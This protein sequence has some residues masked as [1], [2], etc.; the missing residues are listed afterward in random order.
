MHAEF[1]WILTLASFASASMT[2]A[3]DQTQLI[4]VGAPNNTNH[5][6]PSSIQSLHHIFE[7]NSHGVAL[8]DSHV[9]SAN[10]SPSVLHPSH[11]IEAVH[12]ISQKAQIVTNK[13]VTAPISVRRSES[14]SPSFKLIQRTRLDNDILENSTRQN[15][16]SNGLGLDVDADKVMDLGEGL[17]PVA[18]DPSPLKT[19]SQNRE[20]RTR[21]LTQDIVTVAFLLFVFGV[22]MLVTCM[23]VYQV[24]EDSSPVKFY[25]DAR[26]RRNRLICGSSDPQEFLRTFC[27]PPRKIRLRLVGRTAPP[28]A[29]SRRN[30]LSEFVVEGFQRPQRRGNFL[31]RSSIVL[32][33]VALDVSAFVTTDGRLLGERDADALR[34]YLQDDESNPLLLLQLRKSVEWCGWEDVGTNIRQRLRSLGYTG[35]VDVRFE[36]TEEVLIYQNHPWQN[37]THSPVTQALV[38][39]SIVGFL[40]WVPYIWLRRRM[41]T[42]DVTFK[43]NIALDQYW[44]L[45]SEGLDPIDGFQTGRTAR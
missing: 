8:D 34:K 5:Q 18:Y 28:L 29:E 38:L 40:V 32:F 24:S 23:S 33:D 14:I 21:L 35:D 41:V 15:A 43:V 1:L 6:R 16:S 12:P 26:G 3:G 30:S 45:I 31:H 22:T 11:T 20:M 42:V 27:T 36:G 10:S 7:I 4:R 13:S 17:G 39:F 2:I 37:F 19:R 9:H 25:S 44:D